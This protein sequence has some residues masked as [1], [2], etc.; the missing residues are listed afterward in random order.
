MAEEEFQESEVLF[1]DHYSTKNGRVSRNYNSNKNTTTSTNKMVASSLPLS[2]AHHR[3]GAVFR[4]GG[5]AVEFEEY[6]GGEM[7]PPHVVLARRIAGKMAFSVFT[8]HGRTL[9]GRDLSRVRNSVL[10]MTGFL[11]A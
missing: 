10:R 1:S 2:I 3:G 8:G 6:D 11:E 4:C 5:E 9:K 7:V